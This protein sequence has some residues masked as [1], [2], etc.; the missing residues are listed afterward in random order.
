MLGLLLAA[1]TASLVA[2]TPVGDLFT[3]DVPGSAFHEVEIHGQLAAPAWAVR[4]VILAPLTYALTPYLSE[5]RIVGA[6]QCAPGAE[7]IPG[8][9]VHWLYTRVRPPLFSPRDYVV[10][11]ELLRDDLQTGGQVVLE[12]ALDKKHGPP[13][14]E[15]TVRLDADTGGWQL[16]AAGAM[17][18][19]VYKAFDDPGGNLGAWLVNPGNE[20]EIPRMIAAI[21]KAAKELA[22][23]KAPSTPASAKP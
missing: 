17:T 2:H 13:P 18:S 10:R 8:C 16:Q 11:V 20:R 21:E 22:A 1:T 7:S 23:K 15:G 4:E 9:K 6:E 12:W 3:R 14:P 19:F 5:Q